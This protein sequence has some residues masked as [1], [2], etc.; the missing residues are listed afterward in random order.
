ME[1]RT[2]SNM[3]SSFLFFIVVILLY[4]LDNICRDMSNHSATN[5]NL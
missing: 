3:C 5:H 4:E 2:I 1:I